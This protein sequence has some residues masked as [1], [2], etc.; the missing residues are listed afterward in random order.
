MTLIL[1]E[2]NQ[3]KNPWTLV[4]YFFCNKPVRFFSNDIDETGMNPG[5]IFSAEYY[6]NDVLCPAYQE[7]LFLRILPDIF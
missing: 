2:G 7:N 5:A 3:Y 4:E 6:T 1:T